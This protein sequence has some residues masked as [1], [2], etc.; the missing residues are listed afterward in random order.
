MI[1][2]TS[3]SPYG[4]KIRAARGPTH[5]P[6]FWRRLMINQARKILPLGEIARI[7]DIA[8]HIRR[9][10]LRDFPKT[11]DR[12]DIDRTRQD[13]QEIIWCFSAGNSW[14]RSR[15]RSL[16]SCAFGS[17]E[18]GE[19]DAAHFRSA[20]HDRIASR[21]TIRHRRVRSV[22]TPGFSVSA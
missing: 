22:R 10:W 20:I 11:L 18:S 1:S 12:C 21:I 3:Q 16:P 2:F 17:T 14:L 4:Q 8:S 19:S 7:L 9:Q 13:F 15:H 6:H 5:E